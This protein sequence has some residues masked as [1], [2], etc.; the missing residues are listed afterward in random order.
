MTGQHVVPP[1]EVRL[2]PLFQQTDDLVRIV[3]LLAGTS[4]LDRRE[5]TRAAL[6]AAPHRCVVAEQDGTVIGVGVLSRPSWTGKAPAMIAVAGDCRNRGIGTALLRNVRKII[7]AAGHPPVSVALRD[8]QI[9]GRRFAL[10]ND[11]SLVSHHLGWEASLEDAGRFRA[12]AAESALRAGVQIRTSLVSED[13]EL[14]LRLAGPATAGMPSLF[15]ETL[16]ISRLL[17]ILTPQALMLTAEDET[18]PIGLGVIEP[19]GRRG[20]WNTS[21]TAVQPEARGRGVGLALKFAEL[22]AA[23]TAGGRRIYAANDRRNIAALQINRSAG[24]KRSFGI[25]NFI[26]TGEVSGPE[27]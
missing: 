23:A 17:N 14:F 15:G 8:D 9:S 12:R 13:G 20:W 19:S 27:R 3:E 4:A 16:G 22:E 24:M 2:R 25:W 11:F 6:L 1:P 21:L 18:G 26:P 5:A 10:Q 7:A